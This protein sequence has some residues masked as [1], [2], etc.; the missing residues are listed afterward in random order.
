MGLPLGRF[1]L[2][3][4]YSFYGIIGGSFISMSIVYIPFLNG[5]F[6]TSS[7][8]TPYVWL[9]AI[10]FGVVLFVY[11]VMRALVL[12]ARN[13]MRF[14]KSIDGLDLHATRLS[15]SKA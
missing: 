4:P 1:L 5:P 6:G 14:A 13:P 8:T 12:R 7:A 3:N 9:L 11:S 15:I 2:A 10:W